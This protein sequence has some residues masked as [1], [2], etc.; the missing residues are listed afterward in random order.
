MARTRRGNIDYVP[1]EEDHNF[2]D[3]E[4]VRE[5]ADHVRV[6]FTPMGCHSDHCQTQWTWTRESFWEMGAA[7]F[8]E[9]EQP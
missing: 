9:E 5:D 4:F 3:I 2:K 1:D 7:L 6:I 8:S